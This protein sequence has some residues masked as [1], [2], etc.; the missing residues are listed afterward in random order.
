M[1]HGFGHVMMQ[2]W[3]CY[4]IVLY[5]IEFLFTWN[6]AALYSFVFPCI[7]LYACVL[8]FWLPLCCFI[9]LCYSFPMPFGQRIKNLVETLGDS[10]PPLFYDV[11]VQKFITSL[12]PWE[13]MTGLRT[14]MSMMEEPRG[15]GEHDEL[16]LS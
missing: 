6:A 9:L 2:P 1:L 7:V 3:H 11:R 13:W 8:G 12:A 5:C 14:V 4:C 16:L 15:Q 10:I